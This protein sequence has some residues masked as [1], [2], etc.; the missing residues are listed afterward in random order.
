MKTNTTIEK[1]ISALDKKSASGNKR[2]FSKKDQLNRNKAKQGKEKEKETKPKVAS[3]KRKT[4]VLDECNKEVVSPVSSNALRSKHNKSNTL[5][6]PPLLNAVSFKRKALAL[7]EH[8][9]EVASLAL[10][11]VCQ[12]KCSLKSEI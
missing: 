4:S 6:N 10:S 7:D 9:K 8:D 11:N 2:T 12:S 3:S 1:L 5:N